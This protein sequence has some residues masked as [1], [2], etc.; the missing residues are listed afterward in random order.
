M[1]QYANE[2]REGRRAS[3]PKLNRSE[4]GEMGRAFEKMRTALEGKKYAEEYV[5]TL[6][7][8]IKGP[9]SAIRGAAEL[10]GEEMVS[11]QR[12]RFLSNIRVESS[13]IQDIVGRMLD[14]S[15]LENIKVLEKKEKIAFHSL[16]NMVIESKEVLLSKKSLHV[17]SHIPSDVR[18]EGDAF[19]LHQAVSNLIQNAIDF[20]PAG[21]RIELLGQLKELKFQLSVRDHGQGI[22]DYARGRVFEKF[23]SLQRPDTGKKSTGLGLNFVREVAVLHQGE[24]TLENC[25]GGGAR[26]TLVLP[27]PTLFSH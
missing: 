16:L 20:S 19:L 24:V 7:H 23:F 13:R 18:I 1:T 25:A 3:L 21:S 6:T 8:E 26:A 27:Y 14:L 22:P 10:L 12:V 11:E 15:R 5:Q 9:L 17:T 4:I 2:I